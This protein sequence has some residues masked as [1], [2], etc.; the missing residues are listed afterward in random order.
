MYQ[1]NKISNL[2][3][4]NSETPL[5]EFKRKLSKDGLYFGYHPLVESDETLDHYLRQRIPNLYHFKFGSLSDLVSSMT[6]ELKSGVHFHLKDAPRAAIGPDFNRLLVGSNGRFG[7][8]HDVT[9]RLTALPERIRCAGVAL[10]SRESAQALVVSLVGLFI[11]P[12]F[13]KYFAHESL[14][15]GL[16]PPGHGAKSTSNAL[17]IALSGMDEMVR[18][19]EETMQEH[20]ET[21]GHDVK[22]L[23]VAESQELMNRSLFNNQSYEDIR[24]QYREFLWPPFEASH[25]AMVEKKFFEA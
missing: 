19:E 8:I 1:L 7:R 25:Q 18:V 2:V 5:A 14:P 16:L 24:K 21:R 15:A 9:L 3:T 13:F 11:K 17:F 6:F 10:D 22:W 12:L 20:C 4:L 23:D